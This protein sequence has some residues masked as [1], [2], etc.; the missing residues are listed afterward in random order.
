MTR[1][2]IGISIKKTFYVAFLAMC[3]ALFTSCNTQQPQNS[4]SANN[5]D[6]DSL[7]NSFQNPP[8]AEIGRAHV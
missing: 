1:N 3:L 5:S 6:L 7:R 8:Q 4:D 2:I